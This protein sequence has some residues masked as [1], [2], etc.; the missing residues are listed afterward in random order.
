MRALH[1]C[2]HKTDGSKKLHIKHDKHEAKKEHKEPVGAVQ[3]EAS[4]TCLRVGGCGV[5]LAD[6]ISK[7]SILNAGLGSHFRYDEMK[8][9]GKVMAD[10]RTML[11]T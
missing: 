2:S 1:L 10:M 5:C 3:P 7:H 11:T 4:K 8:A 9:A 6:E